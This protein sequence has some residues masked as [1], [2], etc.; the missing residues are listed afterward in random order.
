MV[1]QSIAYNSPLKPSGLNMF[2]EITEVQVPQARV[3]KE[4]MYIPAIA[5]LALVY[6]MQRRRSRGRSRIAY[7]A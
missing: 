4:W 3:A 1:V 7:Q 6:M 2:D 5:L